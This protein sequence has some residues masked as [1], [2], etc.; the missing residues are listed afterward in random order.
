MA[1][2]GRLEEVMVPKPAWYIRK[3]SQVID[4]DDDTSEGSEVDKRKSRLRKIVLRINILIEP[5]QVENIKVESNI[6]TGLTK[7][8]IKDLLRSYLMELEYLLL[9]DSD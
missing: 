1:L 9:G 6:D 8:T 4:S 3:N 7:E 5:G 2:Y